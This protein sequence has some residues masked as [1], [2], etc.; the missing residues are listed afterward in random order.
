MNSFQKRPNPTMLVIKNSVEIKTKKKEKSTMPNKKAEGIFLFK[1]HITV[2]STAD[3]WKQDPIKM[4]AKKYTFL[5][6]TLYNTAK[7]V[8]PNAI[9]CLI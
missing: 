6:L 8:N 7:R 3:I 9:P 5:F 4:L 1:N 2:N